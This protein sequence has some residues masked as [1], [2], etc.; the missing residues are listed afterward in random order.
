[1]RFSRSRLDALL[2]PDAFEWLAGIEDTFITA[3]SPKT[4]RTLDEYELTEHYAR[5]HDDIGLMAELGIR[6]AR[7]GIPWHRINPAR[8]V[9]DFTWADRP[10]ERL[11]ELG[12]EPV[13]D[14]VHYGLPAWI[15]NAFLNPDFPRYMAEYAARAVAWFRQ[16]L[17][18]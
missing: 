7:Y 3:P 2:E 12:I 10:L 11:L 8:G 16:H 9:W 17:L 15:D 5:W 14:L 13:V 18:R 4:G 6:S 1:M